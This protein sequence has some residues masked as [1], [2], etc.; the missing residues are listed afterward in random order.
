M[1]NVSI[2][3]QVSLFLPP[4]VREALDLSPLPVWKNAEEIRIRL[5]RPLAIHACSGDFFLSSRGVPVDAC[6][7]YRPNR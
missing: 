3:E 2:K 7:A 5:E 1:G 4:A 6:E